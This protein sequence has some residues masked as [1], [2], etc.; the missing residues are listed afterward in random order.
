MPP[1]EQIFHVRL[2]HDQLFNNSYHRNIPIVEHI[3]R[4]NTLSD[5]VW[6]VWI[7]LTDQ[8]GSL[9]Y[10]AVENIFNEVTAALI[11]YLLPRDRSRASIAPWECRVTYGLDSDEGKALLA[12]PNSIAVLWLLAHRR[13]ILGRRDPRVTIVDPG[14]SRRMM[15]QMHSDHVV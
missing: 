5:A 3:P 2:N 14:M 4:L 10:Y 11:D 1:T 12:T 8:P 13:E 7:R 9:R 15:T 6:Q